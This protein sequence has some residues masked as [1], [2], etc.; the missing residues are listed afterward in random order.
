MI[1]DDSSVPLVSSLNVVERFERGGE[2]V[3]W[4]VNPAE[5]GKSVVWQFAN[6]LFPDSLHIVDVAILV[7][8]QSQVKQHLA[9]A[10]AARSLL[11]PLAECTD[12]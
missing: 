12:V 2:F 5:H 9:S 4:I 7:Q 1:A 11:Q 10:I 3:V 8:R 6:M